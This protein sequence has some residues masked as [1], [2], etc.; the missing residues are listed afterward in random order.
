[1]RDQSKLI[2]LSL[3]GIFKTMTN[4]SSV[5]RRELGLNPKVALHILIRLILNIYWDFLSLAE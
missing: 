1:M 3:V 5:Y 2:D 4:K